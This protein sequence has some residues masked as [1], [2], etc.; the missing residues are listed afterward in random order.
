MKLIFAQDSS[1]VPGTLSSNG[2]DQCYMK[3]MFL[4]WD[5]RLSSEKWHHHTGF[6]I[7]MIAR[8][9]HTYEF[10]QKTI[11]I[12]NGEFLIIPPSTEHRIIKTAENTNK[13]SIT[14]A[15]DGKN[16]FFSHWNKTVYGKIPDALSDNLALIASESQKKQGFYNRIIETKILECIYLLLR[17]S[18]IND[19]VNAPHDKL[20]DP[21]FSLAVQYI[22]DNIHKWVS[23]PELSAYCALS[24]RQLSR[25]FEKE[26]GVSTAEYIKKERCRYIET[27]LADPNLSL[28]QISELMNFENEYYFNAFFKKYSGMTPGAYRKT[29]KIT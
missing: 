3:H 16:E 2:V 14:F 4:D 17:F 24:G 18:G 19:A 6:E 28:R 7:H 12:E 5:E 23:I 26:T 29:I 20:K 27:L 11:K 13:Y 1:E 21:R 22:S 25:V 9:S 10:E 15:A 8:G